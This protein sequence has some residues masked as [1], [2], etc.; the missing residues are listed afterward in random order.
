MRLSGTEMQCATG[1]RWHGSVPESLHKVTTDTRAFQA[2]AAFLALRGPSFDGH[3]FAASVADRATA[4]IGDH[5]GV[6]S[7]LNEELDLHNSVLE[8]RD[9]LQAFGDIAHAWRTH[10]THTTVIAISGSYGKTSLRSI[11]ETGFAALNLNV[12]ATHANLNNLIGVPQTLLAVPQHADIAIIEC[13]ISEKGEMS[14][15]AA[16]VQ[17]DITILT[18][19]TAAH[20]EG[21]GGLAGVVKEKALLLKGTGWCGLGA[22]V[23]GLLETHQI[24]VSHSDLSVDQNTNDN[25][26]WQLNGCELLLSYQNQQASMSLSLPAAHWASNFA[27]AASII[28]RH[29]N[30]DSIQTSLQDVVTAIASWQPPTGRLQSCVGQHGSVILDDCYNANPVS[31][32]AA[33]DTLR[34][35][36]ADQVAI[37]GDMAELGEA[38]LSAHASL[39]VSGLNRLYLIGT[40]MQALAEKYPQ[41]HWF[42]NTDAALAALAD[43]SFTANDSVLIKA[44][45]SMALE[46]VVQLLCQ[47]EVNHAV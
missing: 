13:G 28:L 47:P 33:I 19:F 18:G 3:A 14:R 22:G 10:L 12:A 6:R 32:Q 16:I 41:A 44:S 29:F 34:A 11:L 23:A 5:D 45:R 38:S 1:G 9:T 20:S 21:L 31:M 36:D 40:Q 17:P 46:K 25:V 15:L 42:A 7:W 30:T 2:G 37:L 24:A 26:Q 8:V 43:E 35:L 4:L 39:D 27:F